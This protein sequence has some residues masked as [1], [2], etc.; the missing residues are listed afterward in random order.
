MSKRNNNKY[1][2]LTKNLNALSHFWEMSSQSILPM[3]SQTLLSIKS[4]VTV[5]KNLYK[6]FLSCRNQI[7][8]LLQKLLS[9]SMT[10]KEKFLL[11]WILIFFSAKK[12]KNY[13][14]RPFNNQILRLSLL[15][16]E[17]L[18]VS[19]LEI[20]HPILKHISGLSACSN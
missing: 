15:R 13:S 7:H 1:F 20:S 19:S 12:Q 14:N 8:L 3:R 6:L 5:Q 9:F 11:N 16:P 2:W 18:P 4:I 10:R 17:K